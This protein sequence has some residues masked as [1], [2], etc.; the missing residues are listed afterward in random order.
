M[1]LAEMQRTPGHQTAELIFEHLK[2]EMPE[3]S[4]STVYR[5]LKGLADIGQ[6]SISDLGN[7]LVYELVGGDP[8]HHLICL[9]CEAVLPLDNALIQSL[10]NQ[11]EACGF[12]ITTT[13][14]CLYGYCPTCQE[15][16][17]GRQPLRA[18]RG[19]HL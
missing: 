4:L 8:H 5:S 13:H 2:N 7:G 18:E 11:I 3:L 14:L 9:G 10:F 12:R 6:V 1:I 15:K 16:G 17:L 19:G